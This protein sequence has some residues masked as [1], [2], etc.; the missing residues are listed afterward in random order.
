MIGYGMGIGL[1]WDAARAESGA[2]SSPPFLNPRPL[3]TAPDVPKIQP[4]LAPR[5]SKTEQLQLKNKSE[6]GPGYLSSELREYLGDRGMGVVET[7]RTRD[8]FF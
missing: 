5:I 7:F 8:G 3:A 4:P 2:G 6:S 1:L